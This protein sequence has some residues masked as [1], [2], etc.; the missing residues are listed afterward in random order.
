MSKLC[1][2]QERE[3]E[4]ERAR[5]CRGS[6]DEFAHT[7]EE[8]TPRQMQHTHTYAHTYARAYLSR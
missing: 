2:P 3:T 6:S 4:R 8:H 5:E 7:A 1:D